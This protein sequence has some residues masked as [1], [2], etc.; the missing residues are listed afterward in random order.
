VEALEEELSLE[1]YTRF[2][3]CTSA[4]DTNGLWRAYVAAWDWAM[5][6]VETLSQRGQVSVPGVVRRRIDSRM[7]GR[8][9]IS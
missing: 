5:E 3:A 1:A 4:L 2:V 6:M 7:E 9:D 8:G